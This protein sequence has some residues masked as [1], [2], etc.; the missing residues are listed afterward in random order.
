MRP[1]RF[2]FVA[3]IALAGASGAGAQ[4]FVGSLSGAAEVPANVSPGTGPVV[5]RYEPATF[6]LT[7]E[8]RFSDL[9]GTTTAAHIHCCTTASNLNAGVATQTPSFSGFPL[10]VTSGSYTHTFDL[11]LAESYNPSFVSASGGV[12]QARARLL[13]GMRDHTAYFN[14]HTQ[15]FPGGE[16]RANLMPD[17]IFA[18]GFE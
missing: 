10:G 16:I 8:A 9:I 12:D 1:L 11:S 17:T 4:I 6:A 2:V 3:A 15:S 14:L 18:N 5:L 13:D 7:I